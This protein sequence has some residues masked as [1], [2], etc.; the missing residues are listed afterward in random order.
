MDTDWLVQLATSG[1]TTLVGAAATDAWQQ[2]RLGFARLLGRGDAGRQELVTARL[3]RLASAVEQADAAERD[4][5]RQQLL[6]AWQAR[7][8][9][10]LEEDPAAAATLSGLRDELQS[11]LPAVQ[12]QWVQ[13]I[14]ASA[15]G[16]TAQGVMF[17]NIINQPA[18]PAADRPRPRR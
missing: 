18:P 10:L 9:D 12:R 1:A 7:L 16:A 2:A 14:T 8:A 4:L 5:V 15:A 17:G 13:H 3:D 11:Q 6:P